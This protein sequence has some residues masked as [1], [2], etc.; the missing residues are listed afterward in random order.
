MLTFRAS[1]AGAAVVVVEIEAAGAAEDA[2]L[3]S[4]LGAQLDHQWEAQGRQC[5]PNWQQ[6]VLPNC[7]EGTRDLQLEAAANA[8]Y[9]QYQNVATTF[10]ADIHTW[11][12][13]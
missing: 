3:L 5:Q 9:T 8:T 12:L 7:V 11:I 2:L 4:A 6:R 10:T 13:P 1:L